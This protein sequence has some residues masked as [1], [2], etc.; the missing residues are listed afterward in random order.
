MNMKNIEKTTC[1]NS[2]S[3]CGDTALPIILSLEEILRDAARRKAIHQVQF[4]EYDVYTWSIPCILTQSRVDM[5][6]TDSSIS[7]VRL[8]LE[9]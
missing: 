5:L 2:N 3:K 6:L 1:K 9:L 8:E 7:K 4:A